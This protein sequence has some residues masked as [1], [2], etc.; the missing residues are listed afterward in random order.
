MGYTRIYPV[1]GGPSAVVASSI[2]IQRRGTIQ[3]NRPRAERGQ[4]SRQVGIR[5]HR[6][7]PTLKAKKGNSTE[8]KRRHLLCLAIHLRRQPYKSCLP[9]YGGGRALCLK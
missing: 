7:S 1:S 6:E 3:D 8:G 5:L 4:R 2:V 9:P